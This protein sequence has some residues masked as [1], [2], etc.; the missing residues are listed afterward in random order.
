LQQQQQQQQQQHATD[1]TIGDMAR[2]PCGRTIAKVL[3]PAAV[4]V[5]DDSLT[6]HG[7]APGV[8]LPQVQC[9]CNFGRA[10][11]IHFV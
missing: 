9:L 4:A 8:C 11:L 5:V 1:M 6:R 7:V 2:A 3:L 10:C